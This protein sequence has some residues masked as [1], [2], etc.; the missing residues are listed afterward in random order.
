MEV[1]GIFVSR[2]LR[3]SYGLVHLAIVQH[4]R[5]QVLRIVHVRWAE[6]CVE[7]RQ[8]HKAEIF[9]QIRRR[10]SGL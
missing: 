10:V 4:R 8:G 9:E 7:V 1:S 3:V 5:R 2:C 6:I